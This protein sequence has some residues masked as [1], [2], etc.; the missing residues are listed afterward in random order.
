MSNCFVWVLRC[1]YG[2]HSSH[3]VAVLKWIR[4][5]GTTLEPVKADKEADIVMIDDF[6]HFVNGKKTKFGYGEPITSRALG[7]HISN[8]SDASLR[9]L[10][11]KIDDGKCHFVTDECS[12]FFRLLSEGRHFYGK[13]LTYPIEATHS[14]LRHGLARFHTCYGSS[15]PSYFPSLTV[16]GQS[17]IIVLFVLWL[18]V[19]DIRSN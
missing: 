8:R 9:R 5:A 4:A 11:D 13:D 15:F 16:S 2:K 3:L 7:W 10:L 18:S 1:F 14:N 6:W 19:S 12:G 17:Y